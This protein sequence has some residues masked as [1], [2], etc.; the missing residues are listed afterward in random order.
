MG[1]SLV[2]RWALAV[3]ALASSVRG[4]VLDVTA[5]VWMKARIEMTKLFVSP[6][7]TL[8]SAPGIIDCTTRCSVYDFSVTVVFGDDAGVS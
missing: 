6:L 2:N 5:E 4:E 7:C 3:V 1:R 8:H